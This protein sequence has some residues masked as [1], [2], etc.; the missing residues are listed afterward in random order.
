MNIALSQDKITKRHIHQSL[1]TLVLFLVTFFAHIGHFSQVDN[2]NLSAFE[3]HDCNLCQQ[4]V[5][6]P[7]VSFESN[8]VNDV[9]YFLNL[10]QQVSVVLLPLNYIS[11]LLRAPPSFL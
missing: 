5:D 4:G 10:T 9:V 7:P 3:L 6:T 2:D 8:L 1:L 11:P